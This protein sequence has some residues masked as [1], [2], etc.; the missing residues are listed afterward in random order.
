MD[1]KDAKNRLLSEIKINNPSK[2]EN[3]KR[4]IIK[5]LERDKEFTDDEEQKED[6]NSY[7]ENIQSSTDENQIKKNLY[8][9]LYSDDNMVQDYI[10]VA[11]GKASF[12]PIYED[13]NDFTIGKTTQTSQGKTIVTDIDPETQSVTWSLNKGV[14]DEDIYKDLTNLIQKFEKAQLKDF[15]NKPKLIQLVKDLKT[16]RNKFKR[17]VR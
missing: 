7:I 6:I 9:Y 15:H 3:F 4:N 12:D 11:L 16:I 14:T 13:V 10:D 1:I 17:T 2:F 8:Y 5:I